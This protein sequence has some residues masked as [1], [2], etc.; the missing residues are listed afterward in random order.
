M[1]ERTASASM[2]QSQPSVVYR[3]NGSN[4]QNKKERYG[5]KVP[6]PDVFLT[7]VLTQSLNASANNNIDEHR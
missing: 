3:A 5:L 1:S 6:L 2:V 4:S 7:L